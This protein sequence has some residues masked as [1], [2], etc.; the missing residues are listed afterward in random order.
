M[1]TE[2]FGRE[3]GLEAGVGRRRVEVWR[4]EVVEGETVGV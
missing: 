2:V 3:I 1:W 4:K